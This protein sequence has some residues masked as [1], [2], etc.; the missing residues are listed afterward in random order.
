VVGLDEDDPL[1]CFVQLDELMP[2]TS[3]RVRIALN[4]TQVERIETAL[5]QRRLL[6]LNEQIGEF[7]QPFR[8]LYE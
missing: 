3:T 6:R 7:K 5:T 2:P 8:E 1:N 4:S